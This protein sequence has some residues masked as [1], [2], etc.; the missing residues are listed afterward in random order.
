IQDKRYVGIFDSSL[1]TLAYWRIKA[2]TGE[3]YGILPDGTGGG[4]NNSDIST[5]IGLLMDIVNTVDHAVSMVAGAGIFANPIGGLSLGI[6]AKY[7]I[8]LVKLYAIVAEVIVI[9]DAAGLEDRIAKELQI[10][11]CEVAKDILFAATG[12]A[13]KIMGG[14]NTL[15]G[16]MVPAEDNPF[17][18]K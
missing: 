16:L 8:T 15:I 12:N 14:L 2:D 1:S 10:L 7:G 4:K 18:C 11:A 9:M 6:V 3:L 5:E 13:G 17:A